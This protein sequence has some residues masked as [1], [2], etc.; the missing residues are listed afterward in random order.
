MLSSR[1]VNLL[2]FGISLHYPKD[3]LYGY[4]SADNNTDKTNQQFHI[5]APDSVRYDFKV[6]DKM[7]YSST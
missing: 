4:F 7:L 6:G 5:L 1:N 2:G 3:T